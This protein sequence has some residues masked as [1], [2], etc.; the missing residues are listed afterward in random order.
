MIITL[1]PRLF[2]V[3]KLH[4]TMYPL[5]IAMLIMAI[6]TYINAENKSF[7]LVLYAIGGFC[8]MFSLALSNILSLTFIQRE[9]KDDMLGKVS[10]FSTAVATISIAPGQLLYGQL[11][12]YKI[13]LFF[14][15]LLTCLLSIGVVR[16]VRW[17]VGRI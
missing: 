1:R 9:V 6:A 5:V 8:I 7:V 3:E 4:K 13:S 16:Y 10:A 11:I 14:I 12:N 15:L 17:N 2:K